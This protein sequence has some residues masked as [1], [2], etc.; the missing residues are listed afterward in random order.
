MLTQMG[1]V[2]ESLIKGIFTKVWLEKPRN[3][4][5]MVLTQG[6]PHSWPEEQEEGVVSRTKVELLSGKGIWIEMHSQSW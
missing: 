6:K 3:Q 1:V 5:V 2:E 4:Q